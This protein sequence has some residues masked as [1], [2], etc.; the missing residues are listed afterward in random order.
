[1][2]RPRRRVAGEPRRGRAARAPRAGEGS[3]RAQG[4]Q[5][6]DRLRQTGSRGGHA[7]RR[8]HGLRRGADRTAPCRQQGPRLVPPSRAATCR[9]REQAASGS[10]GRAARAGRTGEGRERGRGRATPSRAPGPR[11]MRHAEGVGRAPG[12]HRGPAACRPISCRASWTLDRALGPAEPRAAW[13]RARGTGEERAREE[14]DG[15]HRGTRA[16]QTGTTTAV[17]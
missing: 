7:A 6:A 9:P 5:A 14:R 1:V 3:R 2:S 8:Q 13:P 11:A 15:A 4:R 16:E 12:P 17:P 10:H